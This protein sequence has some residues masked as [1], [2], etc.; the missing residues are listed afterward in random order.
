MQERVINHTTGDHGA[1][2]IFV[3]Y[4]LNPLM[5]RVREDH[6]PLGTFLVRMCGIIGGIFSTSGNSARQRWA[7][8]ESVYFHFIILL[9]KRVHIYKEST[10]YSFYQFGQ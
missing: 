5:V 2:G 4:T 10:F 8:T 7:G 1:S 3:K 9:L 6:M